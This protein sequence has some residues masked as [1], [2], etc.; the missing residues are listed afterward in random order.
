[1]HDEV[2]EVIGPDREILPTDLPRLKYTERVIKESARLFP[3]GAYFIRYLEGDV[4]AGK[5][6]Q[7]STMR[8]DK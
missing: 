1:M 4:N 6:I 7:V 8:I 3:I 5:K 2:L